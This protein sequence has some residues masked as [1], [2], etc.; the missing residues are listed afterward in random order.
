M[1]HVTKS[2]AISSEVKTDGDIFGDAYLNLD[3]VADIGIEDHKT[4]LRAAPD[5]VK[6]DGASS[7]DGF[8]R[9]HNTDVK[10]H[11]LTNGGNREERRQG[12]ARVP[13]AEGL[14]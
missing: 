1:S 7:A 5:A 10:R 6:F 11:H 3:T 13:G 9:M 4:A 2:L 12:K 14:Q 8:V